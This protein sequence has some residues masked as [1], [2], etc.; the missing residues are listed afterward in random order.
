MQEPQWRLKCADSK[1]KNFLQVLRQREWVG[2][3]SLM[4]EEDRVVL[5]QAGGSCMVQCALEA[6]EF[7]EYECKTEM[8]VEM[9]IS[10]LCGVLDTLVDGEALELSI[11]P[12]VKEIL[13]TL[14]GSLGGVSRLSLPFESIPSDV[15][16]PLPTISY[17]AVGL[18]D[19]F[20]KFVSRLALFSSSVDIVC[21]KGQMVAFTRN[22]TGVCITE[23]RTQTQSPITED[24]AGQRYPLAPL[25]TFMKQKFDKDETPPL[26]SIHLSEKHPVLLKYG[27]ST[28][29]LAQDTSGE[30]IAWS[31]R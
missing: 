26:V 22:P 12:P 19:D 15:E 10:Q 6:T 28:C 27:N 25:R 11:A 23:I 16:F 2:K 3:T 21:K 18:I 7:S 4:L 13:I 20:P 9:D 5:V 14:S 1:L 17:E 31:Q 30:P 24:V 29:Y 8:K